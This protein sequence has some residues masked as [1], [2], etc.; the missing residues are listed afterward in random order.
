MKKIFV[1]TS[2]FNLKNVEIILETALLNDLKNIELSS[3]LAYQKNVY[4]IILKYKNDL[5]FLIHNYFPTPKEP[6]VL[7][8]ASSDE[9]VISKSMDLVNR[10]IELSFKLNIEFYSLHCGFTF[11]S[12]GYHLGK[13]SQKELPKISIE[14]SFLNFTKNLKKV[15]NYARKRG[16]KIAIENNVV[17]K[18][19]L[20][21]E[22]NVTCLGAGIDGLR[23]IFNYID[24][25]NLYLLLDIAHA[26]ININ[27]LNLNILE[28]IKEFK[29]KT[30][31]V[32]L[33]DN[34]GINDTNEMILPDSDILGYLKFFRNK[35]LILETHNL[36]INQVKK[37]LRLIYEKARH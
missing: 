22:E 2:V 32:H 21:G 9:G 36:E 1:S 30:I 37:Q 27:S 25:D 11:N 24:D 12:D 20:N 7:N 14:K 34:D 33:S 3:N 16:I 15:I 26:K 8:L 29:D 5:N 35:Y 28:L 4:K 18:E 6:F 31:A 17:F 10:A 19:S 23:K 13:T